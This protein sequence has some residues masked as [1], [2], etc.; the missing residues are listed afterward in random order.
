MLFA[1]MIIIGG[2]TYTIVLNLEN[3]SQSTYDYYSV[4]KKRVIKPMKEDSKPAWNERAKKYEEFEP[5]TTKTKPSEWWVLWYTFVSVLKTIIHKIKRDDARPPTNNTLATSKNDWMKSFPKVPGDTENP[6]SA[7]NNPIDENI[8]TASADKVEVLTES[9]S[10]PAKVG[11]VQ[12]GHVSETTK[13]NSTWR[14]F[15][16]FFTRSKEG[17]TEREKV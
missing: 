10:A 3:L 2:V 15:R 5:I 7:P 14:A 12:S 9:P 11:D 13:H 16:R 8:S 1:V 6:A 4:L 17:D